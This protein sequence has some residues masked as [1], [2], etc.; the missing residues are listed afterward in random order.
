MLLTN[1]KIFQSATG[2]VVARVLA[3]EWISWSQ[4]LANRPFLMTRV[5][6]EVIQV[7]FISKITHNS[8]EVI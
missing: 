5:I 1:D 7:N 4:E 2:N 6:M 3:R 8:F